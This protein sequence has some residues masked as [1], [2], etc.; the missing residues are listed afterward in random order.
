MLTC[1]SEAIVP[2]EKNRIC[3]AFSGGADS[4][5]LLFSAE[6]YAR[7]TGCELS[8]AHVHHAIR[9][10]EADRD[11]SFCRSF[12][13]ERGIPFVLLSVDAPAYSKSQK[14]SLETA[15]REERYRV[16]GAYCSEHRISHLLTAHH[17]DD[18]IETVLQRILRGT[19][20]QGLSG[21]HLSRPLQPGENPGVTLVRPFLSLP[22]SALL[23][24]CREEGISF[25]TDS[26]NLATDSTRNRIRN[27]LIPLLEQFNPNLRNALGRL[28][29]AAARDEAFFQEITSS[30]CSGDECEAVSLSRIRALHPAV[31]SRVL[32]ALYER[33]RIRLRGDTSNARSV[34]ASHLASME[35]ILFSEAEPKQISLPGGLLFSVFPAGDL[36]SFRIERGH[37]SPE[38][39]RAVLL[40]GIPAETPWD[41]VCLLWKSGSHDDSVTKLK[42][43]YKF[44]ITTT[45]LS[46][47][48]NGS[49]QIRSRK[50][51]VRERYRCG[52]HDTDVKD[53][54]SSHKIP[55]ED[56]Y[57]IPLFCDDSGII[58][59]P[60][61]GIRDDVNPRGNP[62][63]STL[64][65]SYFSNRRRTIHDPSGN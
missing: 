65:L 53:A 62:G 61:C 28:S 47:T 10:G 31:R 15:A 8:A 58:W 21:I 24:L 1:I 50:D 63:G 11:A 23:S 55:P 6:R 27:E 18:Q 48:M 30:F 12:C 29:A 17:A 45:I 60:Y 52:G 19:D 42:N 40:P 43:I 64:H 44:E 22:K 3:V 16:L 59:I 36:C 56:R 5:A 26:T 20:L 13:E 54:V 51:G 35:A 33:E 2:S 49:V 9:G 38:P 4:C 37:A 34:T 25:V 41:S 57:R 7:Q 46:D 32:L 14:I 39:F